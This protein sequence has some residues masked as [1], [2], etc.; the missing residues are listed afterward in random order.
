VFDDEFT[1]Q[2][3]SLADDNRLDVLANDEPVEGYPFT[4]I[5]VTQGLY[6]TVQHVDGGT[7]VTYEPDPDYSG[8]DDFTYVVYDPYWGGIL[9]ANVRIIVEEVNDPP[10]AVD[11]TA[12]TDED[13]PVV[14]AVLS[15]DYDIDSALDPTS[16]FIFDLSNGQADVDT[17]TGLV[18]YSPDDNWHGQAS[19]TY[20]V[21]D[22]E[23]LDS[24]LCA[25]ADV[26][27][28]VRPGN[29]PPVA[30]PGPDQEV[31]TLTEVTLD[32]SGSYDPDGDLELTYQW[33]QTGGA[34]VILSDPTAQSLTFM[35]PDDPDLLEFSLTVFD[36]IGQASTNEDNK[37]YVIVNNQD[38]I[39]DAGADQRVFTRA[40]VTLDGSDSYDPDHDDLTYEWIQSSGPVVS[41]SS[42]TAVKPTFTAPD[43][44]SSLTFGLRVRDEY[45]GE[46]AFDYVTVDVDKP[47]ILRIYLPLISTNYAS[48]PDLVVKSITA[49]RNNIQIVIENQGDSAVDSGFYVDAYVNPKRAPTNANEGWDTPGISSGRGMVW[50]IEISQTPKPAQ[51]EIAPFEPGASLTLSYNDA[52]YKPEYSNMTWPMAVGT[53]IYAQVD[54]FPDPAYPDGLVLETHEFYNQP[55][56]NIEG[57]VYSTSSGGTAADSTVTPGSRPQAPPVNLP[58]RP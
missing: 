3:D 4:I 8:T 46:S 58:P 27:I 40:L 47:P 43:R 52:F 53:R 24:R 36:S 25:Q 34:T 12:N 57:P 48:L 10:V 42:T 19:F 28:T 15:N 1:V 7:L 26:D 17:T 13:Q 20:R 38:P 29:D 23:P 49:T 33:Q 55:Y 16:L 41:L 22:D 51:G 39:A 2:E 31:D 35:A 5:G 45:D 56:N 44:A 54:T 21:C 11:D 32:G 30:D 9:R 50:A 37:T 6:G 14:I 18:T